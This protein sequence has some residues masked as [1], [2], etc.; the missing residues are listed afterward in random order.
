M[1]AIE[2]REPDGSIAL[3]VC[4][5]TFSDR[6]ARRYA[7]EADRHI[8]QQGN[9]EDD[10][11]QDNN[12][13]SDIFEDSIPDYRRKRTRKESIE[14]VRTDLYISP[15]KRGARRQE[16]TDEV[17]KGDKNGNKKCKLTRC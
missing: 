11:Q 2:H 8:E 4:W 16:V 6:D 1:V 7:D 13:S 12:L 5:N 15:T 3:A 14:E 9:K 17:Y 10:Q